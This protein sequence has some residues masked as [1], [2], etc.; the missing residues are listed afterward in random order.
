MKTFP[1]IYPVS[2]GKTRRWYLGWMHGDQIM[3]RRS[4]DDPSWTEAEMAQMFELHHWK[5]PPTD[6]EDEP[7]QNQQK[8]P[9]LPEYRTSPIR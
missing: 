9:Y 7:A 5:M 2:S 8:D 6:G 3:P 1:V 4:G